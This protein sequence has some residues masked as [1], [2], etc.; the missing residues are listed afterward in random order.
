MATTARRIGR[1]AAASAASAGLLLAGAGPALADDPGASATQGPITLS[2][3]Q[4]TFVCTQRIPAILAR[5]DRVT[6][7]INADVATRGSTAWLQAR[8]DRA[9]AAGH[10]DVAD[11]IQKRIDARPAKLDSLAGA[12]E[13]VADFRDDELCLVN[14]T[15]FR[16]GP[17]RR[18]VARPRRGPGRAGA[19]RMPG[20]RPRRVVRGLDGRCRLGSGRRGLT[21][22]PCRCRGRGRGRRTGPRRGRRCRR[23]VSASLLPRPPGSPAGAIGRRSGWDGFAWRPRPVTRSTSPTPG[24]EAGSVSG[25]DPEARGLVLVVED[26][27]AI[28]DLVRLYLRRE[29][30]GVHVESDGAGALDATAGCTLS[31]SSSTSACPGWTAS[32]S[33]AGCGRPATGPPCCS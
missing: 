24:R 22:P 17:R 26:D 6:A 15:T 30:F 32:R 21:G 28:A 8:Q 18:G 9:E 31:P 16:G 33:A 27:R 3:E 4:A 20:R 13:R 5:I 7:R 1:I 2:P 11:R 23:P 19:R 14:T 25:P 29:G 10:A 12:K